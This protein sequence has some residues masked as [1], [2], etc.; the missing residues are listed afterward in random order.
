MVKLICK[1]KKIIVGE[2]IV[3]A[4]SFFSRLKG[5][6]FD[7]S[8]GTDFDGILIKPC[9][10]IHTFFM[11]YSIDAVFLNKEYKVVKIMRD[12]R[13]W[14]MTG[15]YF[16]ASQVLEIKSGLLPKEISEDDLLDE[17]CIS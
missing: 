7:R 14:R 1:E 11:N 4:K 17:I 6:M 9:N 16:R 8:L 2:R 5:L 15:I 3:I 12:L 13:P 10:S